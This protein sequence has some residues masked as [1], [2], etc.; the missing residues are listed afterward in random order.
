MT[1][2]NLIYDITQTLNNA[3]DEKDLR[4]LNA[5]VVMRIK[6]IHNLKSIQAKNN[7]KVGMKVN[8]N[9]RR[10]YHAGEIIKINRTKAQVRENYTVWNVPMSMLNM[11]E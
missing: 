8:W 3:A 5:W 9:G 10:G 7:L 2:K 4:E 6:Q 11:M 1:K